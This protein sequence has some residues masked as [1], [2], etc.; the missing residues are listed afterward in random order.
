MSPDD[1]MDVMPALLVVLPFTAA[2]FGAL[3]LN[4]V[5]DGLGPRWL[6]LVLV[7]VTCALWVYCFLEA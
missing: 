5:G 6:W 3:L 2:V 1:V 4:S 7:V